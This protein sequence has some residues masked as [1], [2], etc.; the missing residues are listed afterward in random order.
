MPRSPSP[1][2]SASRRRCD[3]AWQSGSIVEQWT[4]T[5]GSIREGI[6]GLATGGI[7]GTG[8]GLG[9]PQLVPAINTDFVV[10][11]IGE[12]LGF[13]GIIA[14]FALYVL[15][16]WR[17]LRAA[18]RARRA[19]TPHLA[20]GIA[21][22]LAVEACVITAS[23]LGI[24]P[25][26]GV[27]TPFLSYG[28]SSMVA[29]CAAV[30]LVL[31]IA[32]TEQVR[33]HMRVPVRMLALTLLAAGAT[34]VGRAASIQGRCMSI[35]WFGSYC[36]GAGRSLSRAGQSGG[37]PRAQ[38][39]RPLV[40]GG[41]GWRGRFL[42]RTTRDRA[43]RD[44]HPGGRSGGRAVLGLRPLAARARLPSPAGA[45][46]GPSAVG[47]ARS[48]ILVPADISAVG[49]SADPVSGR[50][51]RGRHQRQLGL[52]REHRRRRCYPGHVHRPDASLQVDEPRGG[53]QAADD[54]PG[55]W[56]RT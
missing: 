44:R 22:G 15:L 27:V 20:I 31:G 35:Y 26:S 8:I 10:A 14:V 54:R 51:R 37:R 53:R 13:A 23:M 7:T 6:L 9:N 34:I 38:R 43:E 40:G 39:G 24:L 3:S 18:V 21:L 11:A 16:C 41:R 5:R 48:S 4:A 55:F 33:T 17:C 52:G 19:T 49:F 45:A 32:A 1:I 42:R 29:N 25:L 56:R 30:G 12:E 36:S 2:S 46:R 50:A 47:G 28:R